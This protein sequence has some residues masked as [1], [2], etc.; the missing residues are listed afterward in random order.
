M[1]V[2]NQFAQLRDQVIALLERSADVMERVVPLLGDDGRDILPQSLR[3]RATTVREEEF[4]VVVVG[5]VGRGKSMVLNAMMHRRL[6]PMDVDE[7]TAT[8]NFL[9]YPKPE[10]GQ[11]PE[12]AQ[13]YFVDGRAP[14]HVPVNKLED[15]VSRLSI[16]GRDAVAASVDH[17]DVFVESPFLK[18][19]VLL[20]DTPGANTTTANH[21]RITHDQIDRSN[22]AIF[23]LSAQTPVTRSDQEFLGQVEDAVARLFFVVNKIDQVPVNDVARI[24]DV[25][26]QKVKN[27]VSDGSKLRE[28][29]VFGIS[30][31]KAFHARCGYFD[32]GLGI[33]RERLRDPG[34]LEA[35]L[36]ESRIAAFEDDLQRYLFGGGKGYDLLRNPLSFIQRETSRATSALQ[37]QI[38]VLDDDFDVSDLELQ[39]EKMERAVA[40]RK[41]EL[42][43]ATDELSE[44]LSKALSDVE[45]ALGEKCRFAEKS[46]EELLSDYDSVETLKQDWSDG[47]RLAELPGR[48]AAE[49]ARY[50]EKSMK[51]AVDGVLRKL[52]RAVREQISDQLGELSVEVPELPELT[53]QVQQSQKRSAV[54]DDIKKKI[55]DTD[56]ELRELERTTVGAGEREYRRLLDERKRHEEEY[57]FERQRLGTRPEIRISQRRTGLGALVGLV[58]GREWAEDMVEDVKDDEE[59][60]EYDQ[61]CASLRKQRQEK[62]DQVDRMVEDAHGKFNEELIAKKRAETLGKMEGNF[63]QALAAE[64]TRHREAI[65]AEHARAVKVTKSRV[66]SVFRDA[67]QSLN[68]VVGDSIGT[69]SKMAADFIEEVSGALDEGLKRNKQELD[70]LQALKEQTEGEREESRKRVETSLDGLR[71]L[72][73]DAL[74]LKEEHTDFH[75]RSQQGR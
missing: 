29:A 52:N 13:V 73:G 26:E 4:V 34:V 42:A 56:R 69:T 62:M 15:Y 37:R 54:A 8:V 57:Q 5:E 67:L 24:L 70:T 28:R 35:L 53:L 14:E 12:R 40:E 61:R 41:H 66:A 16:D 9:R 49:L 31:A 39:I 3:D 60:R 32:S 58:F 50:A 7:C 19:Q 33:D 45:I 17:A 22:A 38:A 36:Q 44:E 25:V 51:E 6:L 30:A 2:S 1:K 27:A 59:R 65:A 47:L 71:I 75:R 48:K 10:A 68:D 74:K 55:E 46:L 20:V 43:G 72:H 18:E 23:L 64:E 63:R 11:S 21:T